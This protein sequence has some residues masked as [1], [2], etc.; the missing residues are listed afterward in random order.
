ML[1]EILSNDKGVMRDVKND[2]H[3]NLT[4]S[5]PTAIYSRLLYELKNF[6]VLDKNGNLRFFH[7]EFYVV[8]LKLNNM[9]NYEELIEILKLFKH[10]KKYI[11]L[12]V[13]LLIKN[14]HYEYIDFEYFK[15]LKDEDIKLYLIIC[16]KMPK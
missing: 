8:S 1:Y 13:Y 4:N 5:L 15:S 3:R 12:Y 6:I 2:Y 7:R 9:K 11:L 14:N 10:Q 16:K